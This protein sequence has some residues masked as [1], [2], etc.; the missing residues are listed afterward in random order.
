M[1]FS[2]EN[3]DEISAGMLEKDLL[4]AQDY[5]ERRNPVVESSEYAY[6][7]LHLFLIRFA[8]TQLITLF[9]LCPP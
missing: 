3:I 5:E 9:T 4:T 8:Q 1:E 6:R 2:V 7:V